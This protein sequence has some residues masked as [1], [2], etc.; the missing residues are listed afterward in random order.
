VDKKNT[1]LKNVLDRLYVKYNH[2]KLIAPDPLQFV[3]RYSEPRDMEIT[4]L[5][6]A[7]L[8]YGRVAQIE[9][10]IASLL[11]FMGKS[12]FRF[13]LKFNRTKASG[14]KKFKH[15]FTTGRHLVALFF[16]LKEILS[17]FGSIEKFFAKEYSPSDPN[18]IPALSKFSDN[19]LAMHPEKNKGLKYLL[20]NPKDGS[21]CKR[22]NL[23]LRWMVRKD[24]VDTGLWKSIDK[25]KLIVPVDVHM[26]RLCKLLGLYRRKT[27][28]LAAALEITDSFRFIEPNDPVKYDFALSRVGILDNCTGWHRTGCEFCE[29]F[30][31]CF[32]TRLNV[33]K[34]KNEH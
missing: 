4:A 20:S 1:Q 27:I 12:P 31:F 2:R 29:L 21:A 3:Y 13:I 16:L 33:L 28:S 14:L 18:I 23:F 32:P 10:S 24:D 11:S 6:A 5:F 15:R 8:A 9:K 19:L 25:S 7:V 22:L 34:V 26:A 30:K 17:E